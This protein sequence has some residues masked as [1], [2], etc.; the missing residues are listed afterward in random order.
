MARKRKGIS[1]Y[2]LVNGVVYDLHMDG[3]T[4]IHVANGNEK[5]GKGV[6]N[7]SLLPGDEPLKLKNGVQLTNIAGTCDGCCDGCKGVCYAINSAT[8]HHNRVIKAWGENT[9]LAKNDMETFFAEL[10]NFINRN[11]VSVM[12]VHV[13]GEFFSLLY[14][15]RTIKFSEENP[16]VVF[17]FYTK[18]YEWLEETEDKWN[19]KLPE[20][21]HPLVSIWH[22]NYDNPRGFAEFIYDDGTDPGLAKLFHCPAVDK[23]GHETGVTCSMCKRCRKAKKGDKIAVYA[24]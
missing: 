9:M 24:H 16:D 11:E 17:Y 20:N 14:M 22:K 15:I 8:R 23:S 7:Y 5:V 21:V 18:R 12:R 13:G 1:D 10:Q 19:G 4:H 3:D 6:W 2:K